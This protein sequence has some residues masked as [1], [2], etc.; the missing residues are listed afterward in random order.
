[1]GD[2]MSS[3]QTLV[4]AAR[5]AGW[6]SHRALEVAC[7]YIDGQCADEAF[8]QFVQRE[9]EDDF[10]SAEESDVDRDE[11]R[12][13]N[14]YFCGQ[15]VDKRD[16]IPVDDFNGNDGGS[17]CHE[18]ST[19]LLDIINEVVDIARRDPA[20]AGVSRASVEGVI[21]TTVKAALPKEF[22]KAV[23]AVVREVMKEIRPE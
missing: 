13:V 3:R 23:E 22:Q 19:A 9:Q 15:H 7:K 11:P 10:D 8:S 1:M 20:P 16:C 21:R 2:N 6:S 12:S 18:C 17:Q 4:D 5:E 14:C